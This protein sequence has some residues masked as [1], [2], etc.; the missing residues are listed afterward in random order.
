MSHSPVL[1]IGEVFVDLSHFSSGTPRLEVKMRLGGVVHAARA[2]WACDIPYAVAVVCPAYLKKDAQAYLREHGC[3]DFF[4]FGTINGSPNVIVINDVQEVG[5]Q[6][7]EDVLRDVRK[8][9]HHVLSA[10]VKK[11]TNI[12]IF[13]GS[14]SLESLKGCINPASRITIDIA[15]N[16]ENIDKLAPISDNI[17]NIVLSTS[18][19]LFLKIGSND[20]ADL[21]RLFKPIA[22]RL[23]LKEN[24]GGSRLFSLQES[25]DE[26]VYANL[27]GTVNSVGVGDAYTAVFAGFSSLSPRDA[28]WRG[29]Q[30]AT[31]YAQT[32]YPADFKR[33]VQRDLRLEVDE[34]R[35]LDGVFLP[36]HDRPAFQIYL[37]APDF[38]YIDRTIIERAVAALQYHNFVVRRPVV[39]NGEAVP[40]SSLESLQDFFHKDVQLLN[41]C[42]VVFAIPL[43]R[44]PGTLVEMGMA[45]NMGKPVIT[46][47]PLAENKN[48][49]VMCGSDAYSEDLDHC[50]N[51]MFTC[52][53]RHRRRSL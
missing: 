35:A 47:D 33:N 18:S 29:M 52:L 14:Y 23:L 31:R 7:Y 6:G 8:C 41:E 32:T 2:L 4:V 30:V 45:M 36:W 12:V 15:Y 3:L 5:H 19:D 53:S 25:T 27:N 44:D 37:A 28:V 17:D 50:L 26:N 21:I 22:S 42:A 43:Q 24:R 38:T 16:I 9:R 48:T 46:F 20:V 34:V 40:G 10:D 51:A 13:P 49:M 11:Y 1:L 39:E